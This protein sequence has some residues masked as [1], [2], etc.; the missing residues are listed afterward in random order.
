MVEEMLCNSDQFISKLCLI[1]SLET[2]QIGEEVFCVWKQF[3]IPSQAVL[4]ILPILFCSN[5][6]PI[7]NSY[8]MLESIAMDQKPGIIY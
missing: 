4:S 3:S 1:I 8:D 6:I 2:F 5:I 7:L